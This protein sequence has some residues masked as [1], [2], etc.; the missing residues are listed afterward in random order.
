M[1]WARR[2]I[3]SLCRRRRK[4]LVDVP[5]AFHVRIISK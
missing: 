4:V 5:T 2:W 3:S 1:G